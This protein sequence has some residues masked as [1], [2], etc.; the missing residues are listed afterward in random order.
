MCG[1]AFKI[2]TANN[3]MLRIE[4]G[5]GIIKKHDCLSSVQPQIITVGQTRIAR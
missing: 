3:M 5:A 2:R 4:P 1:N